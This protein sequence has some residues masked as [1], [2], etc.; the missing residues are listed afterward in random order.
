MHEPLGRQLVFTA[1][2][3]RESFERV[4]ADAG[5]SLA[6]W[7]VL[8]ALSDAGIV[9]QSVLASHVRLEGAT[10]THHIDRLEQQGLVRRKLDPGDRRVRQLELTTSG[11]SLH[12]N[13][14]GAAKEFEERALQ[15]LDQADRSALAVMLERIRSNLEDG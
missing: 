15:G 7:I 11:A 13:L 8:S 3:M 2:S 1:K 12:A 4:L 6:T 5:G 9:S 10:I 14:L